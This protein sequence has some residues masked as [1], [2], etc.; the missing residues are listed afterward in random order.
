L[1]QMGRRAG[2]STMS[3]DRHLHHRCG[4]CDLRVCLAPEANSQPTANHK[5]LPILVGFQQAGRALLRESAL[6]KGHSCRNTPLTVTFLQLKRPRRQRMS[7]WSMDVI[8]MLS[9]SLYSTCSVAAAGMSR[10]V[11]QAQDAFHS[12][13]FKNSSFG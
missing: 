2:S 4:D 11:L 12:I 13:S 6:F 5:G 9:S 8:E 7:A 10:L 3:S 1:W